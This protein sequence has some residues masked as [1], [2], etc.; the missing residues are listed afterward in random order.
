MSH[1]NSKKIIA[2]KDGVKSGRKVIHTSVGMYSRQL[3]IVA[4]CSD[5]T[6]WKH[7]DAKNSEWEQLEI[8]PR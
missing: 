8:I 4:T 3:I 5:G 2:N 6:V 1:K 7:S